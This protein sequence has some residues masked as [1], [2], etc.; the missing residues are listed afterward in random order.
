MFWN[1]GIRK[2]VCFGKMEAR[3]EY[4]LLWNSGSYKKVLYYL[5]YWK[6]EKNIVYYGIVETR[7]KS[8][9]FGIMEF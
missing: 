8:S 2:I 3:K 5:E 1:Y 4:C 9:C 7:R 6:H